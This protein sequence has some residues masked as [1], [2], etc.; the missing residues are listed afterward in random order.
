MLAV[1]WQV[2]V[3]RHPVARQQRYR[4]AG[5]GLDERIPGALLSSDDYGSS[6]ERNGEAS[7]VSAMRGRTSETLVIGAVKLSV[8]SEIGVVP[9]TQE[10]QA[11]PEGPDQDC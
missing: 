8:G 2:L 5:P 9:A 7:S 3:H 11:V 4:R 6:V 1:C 10:N